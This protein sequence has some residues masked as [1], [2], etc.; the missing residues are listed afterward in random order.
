MKQGLV[1]SYLNAYSNVLNLEFNKKD[2][3][4]SQ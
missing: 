4:I 2:L 3:E 1:W